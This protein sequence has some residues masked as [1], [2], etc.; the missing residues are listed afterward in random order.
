MDL[1]CGSGLFL[2]TLETLKPLRL[3]GIDFSEK[4]ICQ[5]RKK[6]PHTFFRGDVLGGGLPEAD[7]YTGLGLL[8]WLTL[9]EVDCLFEKLKGKDFLFS[10]SERR[11]SLLRALHSLFVLVTYG[12]RSK[13]YRPSYY[14]L[15]EIEEIAHRRNYPKIHVLRHPSLS[16]GAFVS[17][18]PL[19]LDYFDSVAHDYKERSESIFWKAL[20]AVESRAIF[21]MVPSLQGKNVLDACAGSGFYTTRLARLMPEKLTAVDLSGEMLSR[22][23]I[24]G[25]EKHRGDVTRIDFPE[26]FD[27]ILCAGGLEFIA[28]PK[29]F[30]QRMA[31]VSSPRS[32]LLLL[33]PIEGFLGRIYQRFHKKHGL[34]IRLFNRGELAGLTSDWKLEAVKNVH[35]FA[36]AVR[37]G[38]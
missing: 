4:A 30:F 11:S 21:E 22:I 14:S 35:P 29:N 5:A 7:Y 20:R 8:D 28:D 19:S 36:M 13:G 27:V 16:F 24:P 6:Y 32:K 23:S 12:W 25:V 3:F 17:S 37:Y 1:G 2:S 38:K 33:L 9:E 26:L 10:F 34:R 31:E 18:F 15:E